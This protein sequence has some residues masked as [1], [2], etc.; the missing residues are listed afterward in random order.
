MTLVLICLAVAA[1]VAAAWLAKAQR[2]SLTGLAL[3]AVVSA[4]LLTPMGAQAV[5]TWMALVGPATTFAL[6]S[7]TWPLGNHHG[8]KPQ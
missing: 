1:T 4:L 6:V 2:W 7:G 5:I 3:A 8:G